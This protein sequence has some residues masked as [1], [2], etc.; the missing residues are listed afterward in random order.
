[1]KYAH[2][3]VLALI[4]GAG[5]IVASIFI[6]PASQPQPAEIA[7]QLMLIFVLAAALH[8]GR[9]GGF[10]AALVAIA[11]YIA[12]RLPLLQSQG[13]SSEMIALLATRSIA[14]A[15]VGIVGGELA[16][17]MKYVFT[18]FENDALIDHATGVYSARYAADAIL[19]GVG[20][21][22][23]YQTE[24]SVVTISLAQ[25]LFGALKAS[26]VRSTMRQVAAHVR[27]DIRMVDDVAAGATG[28]FYVILPR[29]DAAGATVVA[30]RLS[31]GVQELLGAKDDL[32]IVTVR[33]AATDGQ[34]LKL[35]AEELN[36]AAAQIT[37]SG[38]TQSRRNSDAAQE[39]VA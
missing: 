34:D 6:S 28:T 23:R 17:R 20:Q 4:L 10:L 25:S 9:R 26:R 30:D 38:P 2:F 33:S 36:P 39:P 13:L 31:V 15:L 21:W 37:P 8:W 1:M 29:T 12:M 35:L 14:Y 3:E 22:E 19:S 7:A 24:F 32:V 18:R 5:A 16:A 11:V 27:N